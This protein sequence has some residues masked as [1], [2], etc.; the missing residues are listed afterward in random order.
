MPYD[1]RDE[2][3]EFAGNPLSSKSKKNLD[4]SSFD[5]KL[6]RALHTSNDEFTWRRLGLSAGEHK[7]SRRLTTDG[8]YLYHIN[9]SGKLSKYLIPQAEDDP[10]VAVSW[11]DKQKHTAVSDSFSLCYLKGFLYKHTDGDQPFTILDANSFAVDKEA[12]EKANTAECTLNDQTL[13]LKTSE[14]AKKEGNRYKSSTPVFTDGAY[15]YLFTF[16]ESK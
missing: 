2:V 1:L 13:T 3:N 6:I 11:Y 9:G 7:F 14:A 5:F 10:L 8:Q 12:M 15:L 4:E 16:R